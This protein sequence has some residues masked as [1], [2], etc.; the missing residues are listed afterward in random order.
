MIFGL[1][2]ALSLG[3]VAEAVTVSQTLTSSGAIND[4]GV[5]LGAADQFYAQGND[6]GFEVFSLATF[7]LDSSL[8][9]GQLTGINDATLS[10]TVNDR[11]FSSGSAFELF[12]TPD[13]FDVNYTGLTFDVLQA[14]G[15]D[16]TQFGSLT[17]L[18]TYSVTDDMGAVADIG[19]LDGGT[20]LA[21]SLNL[22]AATSAAL[23]SEINAGSN[24]S[25]AIGVADVA[26]AITFTGFD[27]NFEP[28]GQPLLTVDATVAAIPEPSSMAGFAVL[29]M[30][31][32][33][34]RR[35]RRR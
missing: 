30:G 5:N 21:Y 2:A 9:G 10:L 17:S 26:D 24:F 4:T 32:V 35:R 28:G 8:F 20:V 3:G 13:D 11:G 6:D 31:G 29:A 22:D 23:I 1:C 33:I 15:I 14:N 16:S 7:A 12:F 27:D 19:D 34:T 18:G 25:F